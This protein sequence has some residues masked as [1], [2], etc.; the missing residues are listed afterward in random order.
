M[1]IYDNNNIIIDNDKTDNITIYPIYNKQIS[2]F[3]NVFPLGIFIF[4]FLFIYC[5][6]FYINK[7]KT[8]KNNS[9]I[10]LSMDSLNTL[11]VYDELPENNCSICLEEFKNE[12]ILKKLN[13]THIFHKD[14]LGIW[15]NNNNNKT[16]P[17]CRRVV[18]V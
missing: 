8:I 7:W 6:C 11:I 10:Q 15:I 16:C 4:S 5:G 12:D 17:L 18:E 1:K 9:I 3:E 14:C 2:S 13:C